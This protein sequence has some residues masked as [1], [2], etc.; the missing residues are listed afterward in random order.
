MKDV[1]FN[2]LHEPWIR[3]M[4]KQWK[5]EEL[6]VCDVLTH[7]HEYSGLA[8]EL[9]VQDVAI[10]RFLLAILHTVVYRYDDETGEE[11]LL[12]EKS[13]ALLRWKSIWDRGCFNSKILLSYLSQWEDRF[14][15][16]HPTR[17][18]YQI[19]E[20][21]IGTGANAAK[22]NAAISESNNKLRLFSERGGDEKYRLS[23]PEAARWLVYHQ[24]FDDS[25]VK[26]VK[27]GGPSSGVSWVG[28]LGVIYAEGKNLFE[29]LMLNLV[30]VSGKEDVWGKPKPQWELDTPKKEERT[31]IPMPDN[32]AELLTLQSRRIILKRENDNVIGY[33][34]IG[35][36]FLDEKNAD[37]EQMTV[38]VKKEGKKNEA[39]HW[40][41]KHFL[42]ERQMW[43]DFAN[44]FSDDEGN[45]RPGIVTWSILLKRRKLV[46]PK[47]RILFKTACVKYGDKNSS[48]SEAFGDY[49]DLQSG[50]LTD[51]TNIWEKEIQDEVAVCD[52]VAFAVKLLSKNLDKAKGKVEPKVKGKP[53]KVEVST[54]Q[55][56]FYYRIDQPFR[57]WIYEI[58]G[59]K[60]LSKAEEL[61]MKWR[62][63]ACGI[64]KEYG[65]EM[66]KQAGKQAMIGHFFTEDEGGSGAPG[67]AGHG[68]R[69]KGAKESKPVYWTS[70]DAWNIF[71]AQLSKYFELSP[72]TRG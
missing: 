8:G 47:S 23:Y 26:P 46:G 37:S 50:F 14:W 36:D 20:A 59:E 68:K 30:L 64:A 15:L 56:E 35:G 7:A 72:H 53:K 32:Q 9:A 48:L 58:S 67:S 51:E 34:Q 27:K 12:E 40:E 33:N 16:F 70:F 4:T 62:K 1:E 49:L 22:L 24:C 69:S 52:R 3:V 61:R 65:E 45:R 25:S 63:Q 11:S 66:V 41:P 13:E 71:N 29:T 31:Q 18:F 10:L 2:L 44:I 55:E 17:P 5:I 28:K 6:S 19:P 39:P 21:E 43:R 57:T 42:P 54:A 60:D 38:W